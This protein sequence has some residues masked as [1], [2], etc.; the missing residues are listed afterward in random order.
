MVLRISSFTRKWKQAALVL[1][2]SAMTMAP[3]PA[4]AGKQGVFL[5]DSVY[6]T[7]DD[8]SLAVGSSSQTLRFSLELNNGGGSAID[9]NQ[10]GVHVLDGAGN[11]Y[12]ASLTEAGQA[13]VYPGKTEEFKFSSQIGSAA[14]FEDLQ[15]ELFAWDASEPDYTRELGTLSAHRAAQSQEA[16]DRLVINLH[17][18]D[19]TLSDTGGIAFRPLQSF[20]VAKDGT[21]T[22]YVD[23]LAENQG[24]ASVKLPAGLTYDLRD[25]SGYLYTA[26]LASLSEALL[27]HQPTK[28]TFQASVPETFGEQAFSLQFTKKAGTEQQTIGTIDGRAGLE[29]LAIGDTRAYSPAGYEG[30]RITADSATFTDKTDGIL[31]TASVTLTNENGKLTALPSLSGLYQLE[32][33]AAISASADT[34]S[35]PAYLGAKESAT[36]RFTALLPAGTDPADVQ[37]V[38]LEKKGSAQGVSSTSSNSTGSTATG[39]TGTG[40]SAGTG[41]STG[42]GA[43]A[44][45]GQTASGTNAAA[46]SPSSSAA[47]SAGSGALPVQVIAMDKAIKD[48]QLTAARVQDYR[49]GD[50]FALEKNSLVDKKMDISLVS[51]R[52]YH[53]DDNGYSIAVA[54]VKVTNRSGSTLSLPA[55]QTELVSKS[56][57]GYGGTR[58]QTVTEQLVNNGSTLVTYS[59]LIPPEEAE[60]T[61]DAYVL[62]LFEDKTLAGARTYLGSYR[63]GI[64]AEEESGPVSFY[65]FS[66]DFR[67]YSIS[68]TYNN[69]AYAYK[70]R[71]ILDIGREDPVVVNES[72]SKLYMEVVDSLDRVIGTAEANLTGT[73]KLITGSK[74]FTFTNTSD[75]IDFNRKIKIYE[76]VQTPNGPVKRLVKVLN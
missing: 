69:G 12:T 14:G 72:F 43:A 76:V 60:A 18:I 62:N 8:V 36:Y 22:M 7:L 23:V 52:S 32:G 70:L 15:V 71:M 35:R 27:P 65:P 51:L 48:A 1:S 39:T 41:A 68:A 67:D 37:L 44:G 20:R 38:L 28:L 64:Q 21:W 10:Y 45:T 42:T 3:Y 47:G 54:K 61:E 49:I 53:T 31:Y 40:S 73:Q 59:F 29:P 55:L 30:L 75:Q 19:S 6:F 33:G 4:M 17:D 74:L 58:Q 46:N 11:V 25:A 34:S 2:V 63:V 24:T 9:F 26:A 66:I 5:S 56:G 13:R 50:S 16:G 57:A